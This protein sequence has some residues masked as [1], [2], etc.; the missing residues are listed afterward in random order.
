MNRRNL[1]FLAPSLLVA[2]GALAKA[3][4]TTEAPPPAQPSA[5]ADPRQALLASLASC[6]TAAMACEAHCAREL[7][8][9]NT[10]MKECASSVAQ[11]LTLVRAARALLSR[12][13]SLAKA[14]VAVC[15][16]A[17]DACAAAC[18]AHEPHFAHGMHLECKACLEACL[19]CGQACGAYLA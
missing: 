11:M 2:G 15:K 16:D 5:P 1:L 3:P 6:E 12:D 19:S 14:T 10:E 4:K 8:A 13:A 17:C 9:G 7:S 18:K